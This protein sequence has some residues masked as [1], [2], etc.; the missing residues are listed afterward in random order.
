[1][2]L[3][4]VGGFCS[5]CAICSVVVFAYLIELSNALRTRVELGWLACY[6]LERKWTGY[7]KVTQVISF[8][9]LRFANV[10]I[11]ISCFVWPKKYCCFFFLTVSRLLPHSEDLVF[12]SEDD[13]YCQVINICIAH[14]FKQLFD[15]GNFGIYPRTV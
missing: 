12:S 5:A 10:E 4:N 7:P 14:I 2:N 8:G 15:G 9:R 6:F 1:M 3:L 11:I 13:V